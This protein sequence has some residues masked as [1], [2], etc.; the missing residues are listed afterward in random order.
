MYFAVRFVLVFVI[1]AFFLMAIRRGKS[2]RK[3][4]LSVISI[5]VSMILI[6]A[7]ALIPF[8][9]AFI[10]FSSP[11]D[12][13]EYNTFGKTNVQ[14]I[15]EGNYSDF[16]VDKQQDA[17]KYSVVP[18]DDNGWK[19]GVGIYLKCIAVES[20]QTTTVSVYNYSGTDDYF[21]SVLDTGNTETEVSDVW[22]SKFFPLENYNKPLDRTFVTYYAH[23]SGSLDNYTV[24]VNGESIQI[25]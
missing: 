17:I 3:K 23:I 13:Y 12:A 22:G 1:L 15:V 7:L 25:K 16:I 2:K 18:K 24:T 9:N 14:L 4:M 6:S 5:I 20:F 21:I 19:I 8:E 11:T 10:S